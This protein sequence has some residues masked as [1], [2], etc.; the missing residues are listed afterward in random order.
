MRALPAV[1]GEVGVAGEQA[2]DLDQGV[3]AALRR[4][5]AVGLTQPTQ[6]ARAGTGRA[7]G[8]GGA[9]GVDGP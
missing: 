1:V 6:P 5:A 4:A 7:G 2:A 3:G 8:T 9:G